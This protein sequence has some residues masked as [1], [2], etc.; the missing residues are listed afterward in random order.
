VYNAAMAS[1]AGEGRL[2]VVA[3]ATGYLGR[4]V[5]RALAGDGWRVRALVRDPERLGEARSAC[6]E[7]FVAQ[8][9]QPD[10]LRGLFDGA[11]VGFSSIGVRHVHRRPT[12]REVDQGANLSLVEEAERAGVARFL[13]VSVLDGDRL[14]DA[15][16]L[17]DAREAVVDRLRASRMQS[18][19]LRP[20]GFFNDMEEIFGMARRGRVWLIGDGRTRVN[21]IHGADLAR[22]AADLAAAPSPPA[23]RAVGG[24]DALSQRQIAE[25][26]FAALDRPVRT[27]RVPAWLVAGLGYAATPLSRNAGALLRMFA[28]LGRRDAVGEPVGERHLADHFR[29]LARA[30]G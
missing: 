17:I 8:A 11:E 13:F 20:T 28:L 21:P 3:G 9:T 2:A 26:A 5:V 23:A 27:A 4:H 25:L 19:V 7:V 15:S 24:P 29:E 16:P 10:A 30:G 1:A 22:V 18:I 12:Y 14:R 6:H